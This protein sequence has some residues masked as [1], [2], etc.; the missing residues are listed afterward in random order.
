MA[1]KQGLGAPLQVF[2]LIAERLA[3]LGVEVVFRGVVARAPGA[4]GS[5]VSPMPT[6]RKTLRKVR[7]TN[8]RCSAS[9]AF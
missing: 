4:A 5:S 8:A 6:S 9:V 1:G 3:D 2:G 7:E